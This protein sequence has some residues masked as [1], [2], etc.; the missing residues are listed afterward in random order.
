MKKMLLVM[1][2]MVVL[3]GGCVPKAYWKE[4]TS[5][6]EAKEDVDRCYAKTVDAWKEGVIS[7]DSQAK[8]YLDECMRK[9]G[10]VLRNKEQA[11]PQSDRRL[12]GLGDRDGQVERGVPVITNSEDDWVYVFPGG[13][14]YHYRHCPLI[15]AQGM[16]GSRLTKIRDAIEQ[17][18]KPCP[19]C[20]K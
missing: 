15:K 7:W 1:L 4:G 2:V 10:Y 19:E 20:I 11:Y 13:E 14:Y 18:Y 16:S 6:K 3:L 17:G 9:K 12:R 8:Q 5:Y